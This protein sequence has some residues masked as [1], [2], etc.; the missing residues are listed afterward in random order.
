MFDQFAFA[1]KREF[2]LKT[3]FA[4]KIF[5]PGCCG[6]HRPRLVRLCI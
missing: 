5:K 2:D 4:L 3:K 1:L 6:L